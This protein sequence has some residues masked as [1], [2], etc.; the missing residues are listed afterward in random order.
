[1]ILKMNLRQKMVI[2]DTIKLRQPDGLEEISIT[3][4][5]IKV[6]HLNLILHIDQMI[7]FLFMEHIQKASDP[8]V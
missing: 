8:V 4:L 3:N 2:S 5:V 6:S 7:I 1:M